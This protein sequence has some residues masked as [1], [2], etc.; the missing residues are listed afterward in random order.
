MTLR[1]GGVFYINTAR[2]QPRTD[3]EIVISCAR[4]EV[5]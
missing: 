3:D 1:G 5:W 4:R 2:L